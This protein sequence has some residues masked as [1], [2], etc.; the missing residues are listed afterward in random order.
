MGVKLQGSLHVHKV[1]EYMQLLI[2]LLHHRLQLHLANFNFWLGVGIVLLIYT[3]LSY[4]HYLPLHMKDG[5]PDAMS[6]SVPFM[7]KGHCFST[8]RQVD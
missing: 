5:L 4:P 1:K 8:V 2:N 6:S 3:V 7:R